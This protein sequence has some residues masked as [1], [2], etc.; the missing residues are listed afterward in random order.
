MLDA[1]FIYLSLTRDRATATSEMAAC[2]V[3]LRFAFTLAS[4]QHSN[5][6]KPVLSRHELPYPPWA[7]GGFTYVI[8]TT[9][10]RCA[11]RKI[12]LS[13]AG[14]PGGAGVPQ[15]RSLSSFFVARS[16]ELV[17]DESTVKCD[18]VKQKAV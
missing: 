4:I 16:P 12:C 9:N 5:H 3:V 15:K 10:S 1:P 7:G 14:V 6:V 2:F 8:S 18:S 17:Y 11:S 13:G